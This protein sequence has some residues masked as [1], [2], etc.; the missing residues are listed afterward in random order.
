MEVRRATKDDAAA[1]SELRNRH[2]N[3][4]LVCYGKV[5]PETAETTALILSDRNCIAHVIYD[6]PDLRGY[7][8]HHHMVAPR[9]EAEVRIIMLDYSLPRQQLEEAG[10]ALVS[11]AAK[12]LLSLGITRTHAYGGGDRNESTEWVIHMFSG[13]FEARGGMHHW[14]FDVGE[15]IQACRR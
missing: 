2:R 10:R 1:M 8:I 13:T 4:R 5:Q 14:T 3:H 9:D 11:V 6:G 15:V 12:E 7:I